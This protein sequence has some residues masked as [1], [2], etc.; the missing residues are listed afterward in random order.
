MIRRR[1]LVRPSN[2]L[3]AAIAEKLDRKIWREDVSFVHPNDRHAFLNC[4]EVAIGKGKHE[5]KFRLT[6]TGSIMISTRAFHRKTVLHIRDLNRTSMMQ[7]ITM[8]F[9]NLM[10][11]S[12]ENGFEPWL[13]WFLSGETLMVPNDD[14]RVHF[15]LSGKA[16][17]LKRLRF[18]NSVSRVREPSRRALAAWAGLRERLP[19]V[20]LPETPGD[21]SLM[22]LAA[23]L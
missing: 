14:I 18:A 4:G 22:K 6:S 3:L 16:K 11:A 5:G 17:E 7:T 19:T 20:G 21:S 15:Q 8:D 13:G 2:R 10:I 9:Q 12:M 1:K 23:P